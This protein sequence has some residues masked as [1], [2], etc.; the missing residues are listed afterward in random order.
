MHHSS[1]T[2]IPS[3]VAVSVVVVA[4]LLCTSLW[5]SANA[6]AVELQAAL[7]ISTAGIG[8]LT[9]AVQ[10]GFILGTLVAAVSGL[11]D[12]FRASSIFF[13]SSLAGALANGVFALP[14]GSFYLAFA[15]RFLV[16]F[17]LAGIYPLGM[18]LVISWSRGST[19][20]TL[21]LLV[22]MLT[23]GSALPH[24]IRAIDTPL[25]WQALIAMSSVLA[26]V[27]GAAVGWLGDGPY[28]PRG[29]ASTR[30]RFGEVLQA[31]PIDAFRRA[32][33][34]Y[35]GHMW[36]LYAFWTLVPFLVMAL[37][38]PMNASQV[39]AWSFLVIAAGAAGCLA[40]GAL[41]RRAGSQRTAVFA[42][43]IS[44]ALCVLYPLATELP[45]SWRLGLLLLWGLTVVADSPQFSSL[46]AA[47]CPAHVVGS[48][49]AIQNAIGFALTTVA[50]VIA[51]SAF[52]TLGERVSWLLAPGPLIGLWAIRRN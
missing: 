30:L 46:S 10:L 2:A 9:G 51:T 7:G 17:S 41:A 32:A 22:G 13:W 43:A 38:Q 45:V 28:L 48:A 8:W 40:G 52:G 5:F 36:E 21:S 31:F 34:G 15:L 44:G 12:R 23:L 29:S 42:L 49:L 3:G 18:K 35:F 4:E 25:S 19:A 27:G 50:I 6:A 11:A 26:V 37:D 20:G 16:G 47:A 14:A 24:G 1:K 39:S 33:F